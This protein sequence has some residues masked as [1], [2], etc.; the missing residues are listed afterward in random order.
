MADVTY[1]EALR[2]ALD[3]ELARDE[4]VYLIGE[5][6]GRFEGSYKVTAGLFET[7][8]VAPVLGR[9]FA[10]A[11]DVPNA[12]HVAVIGQCGEHHVSPDGR[13]HHIIGQR[14]QDAQDTGA[15]L[16]SGLDRGMIGRV[17][18]AGAG[19]LLLGRARPD[20]AAQP[21]DER[22]RVE[23]LLTVGLDRVGGR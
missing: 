14:D 16:A 17:D 15:G 7:L 4:N 8:G 10:P 2:R 22:R 9:D 12:E 20:Q 21:L 13:H 3:E 18:A 23:L 1:R 6:I 5:E 19:D 11:E